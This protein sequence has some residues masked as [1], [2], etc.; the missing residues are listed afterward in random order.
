MYSGEPVKNNSVHGRRSTG[1]G[2]LGDTPIFVRAPVRRHGFVPQTL[3]PDGLALTPLGL[4]A[5][6]EPGRFFDAPAGIGSMRLTAP[7]RLMA[8][9]Y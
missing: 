7:A 1:L 2:L 8:E 9:T 6:N 3:A 5:F 4:A